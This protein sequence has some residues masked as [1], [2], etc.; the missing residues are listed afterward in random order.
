MSGLH[1]TPFNLE[2]YPAF[3]TN[4]WLRH[5]SPRRVCLGPERTRLRKTCN[6]HTEPRDLRDRGLFKYL[7]IQPGEKSGLPLR[8]QFVDFGDYF[9]GV[10]YIEHIRLAL[11]PSAIWIKIDGSPLVNKTPSNHVG[12]L[13]MTTG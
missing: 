10:S 8:Q 2:D 3:L 1:S 7:T 6:C 4:W 9:E 11:R 13:S 5:R 12:L